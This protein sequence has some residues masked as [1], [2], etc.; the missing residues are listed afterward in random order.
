MA[1]WV[2]A[3]TCSRS[4][5]LHYTINNIFQLCSTYLFITCKWKH[6]GD[7]PLKK[8]RLVLFYLWKVMHCD[9]VMTDRQAGR[10]ASRH[11]G[12]RTQQHVTWQS[13]PAQFCPTLPM[14]PLCYQLYTYHKHK[15]LGM[16]ERTNFYL[17]SSLRLIAL[18][19]SLA[20]KNCA[21]KNYCIMVCDAV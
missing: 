16:S 2:K 17:L 12:I 15:V 4:T 21:T 20:S 1:N 6:N 3:E 7:C 13:L 5:K 11:A 9:S 8:G 14:Q 10:Q 19:I 18:L